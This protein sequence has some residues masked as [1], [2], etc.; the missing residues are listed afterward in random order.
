MSHSDLLAQPPSSLSRPGVGLSDDTRDP[1]FL[2]GAHPQS[3]AWSS[4]LHGHKV[5]AAPPGNLSS[6]QEGGGKR[7]MTFSR[8]G[9]SSVQKAL[10][11]HWACARVCQVTLMYFIPTLIL[12]LSSKLTIILPGVWSDPAFINKGLLEHIHAHLFR[13]C[14]RLLPCRHIRAEQSGYGL[15]SSSSRTTWPS[16]LKTYFLQQ[17]LLASNVDFYSDNFRE[18][19]ILLS[20]KC[21]F[22]G[23]NLFL[24]CLFSIF[25]KNSSI[26][27]LQCF[28]CTI[29]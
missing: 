25:L 6:C 7:Q 29:K 27:D 1:G 2:V 12:F 5:G 15:S 10:P 21:L 17:N 19:Y 9:L 16:K 23:L 20:P 8:E 14:L 24:V 13:H 22:L 3:S 26:I 28:R 11:T 18:F 4:R